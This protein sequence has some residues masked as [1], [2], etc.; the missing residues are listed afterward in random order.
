MLLEFRVQLV[1]AFRKALN[2]LERLS[3]Q[4]NEPAWQ[5][6]RDETKVGFKWMSEAL[7]DQRQALGKETS[8]VHYMNEAKLV[9]GVYFGIFK[10]VDR[11]NLSKADIKAIGDLQRFNARLITQNKP[12]DER[13]ECLTNYLTAKMQPKQ[14]PTANDVISDLQGEI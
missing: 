5:F 4:K 13:K 2:D 9:N 1:K 8:S 14:L 10:G 12:Y 11:D 7:E 3:K 6:V